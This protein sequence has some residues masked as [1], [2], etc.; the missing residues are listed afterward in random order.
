MYGLQGV[1]VRF[2]N[3]VALDDVSLEVAP[4]QVSTVVGGDASGKSTL[5]RVLAGVVRPEAGQVTAPEDR[6]LGLLPAS[7]GSWGALSVAQNLEFA[8]AAFGLGRQ[9]ARRRIDELIERAGLAPARDRMAA[10]LSGGMRRKLGVIMAL[11]GRPRL[12]LLDE[13]STGVDPVSR[14]ELWRLISQAAA[15]G[16]AVLTSTTYLDEAERASHVV[17]LDA[18]RV[19]AGSPV[20]ARRRNAHGPGDAQ[21]PGGAAQL[22]IRG[23]RK[24][25]GRVEAVRGVDLD[26]R[27]GE[28]V[29]LL[30][31]NGAG[32][33]TLMRCALGLAAPSSGSSLLFGSPP[34]QAGRARLGYVAQGCGLY[35]DLTPRENAEFATAVYGASVR[36]APDLDAFPERVVGELSLG[37]QRR[38]AFEIALLHS[39]Q[40]LILDEPTSGVGPGEAVGLWNVISEQ[41]AAGVGVLVTTHNTGDAAQCDRLAVLVD[42][43]IV[44]DGSQD[45]IIGGSTVVSVECPNWQEAFDALIAAGHQVSLAGRSVRVL[46][47]SPA[48]V[49]AVLGTVDAVVEPVRAT[50][51]E[52]MAVLAR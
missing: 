22:T 29:G 30:G 31:A 39:P 8:A 42:G 44:A 45:D 33:T 47:A 40:M 18:G 6:D 19:V 24:S 15:E 7:A 5:I 41:A 25:Y 36:R 48:Q 38:I 50:L 34:S 17:T 28:V 4:G 35:P 43:L 2:G 13:P 52:R 14:V 46:D 51:D 1:T 20:P 23:L 49:R 3:V 37:E 32:K 27:P 10:S 26:V 9:E 12:V 11:V 16:A 21:G